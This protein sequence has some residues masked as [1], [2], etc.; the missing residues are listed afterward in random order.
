[1]YIF[2]NSKKILL[3]ESMTL[4]EVL[5]MN[6]QIKGNFAIAVNRV[7]VPRGQ[8]SKTHMSEGDEIDVVYPMQG[9]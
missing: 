3:D 8:Y 6:G 9:G 4:D 1:M 5:K 7:F 2:V